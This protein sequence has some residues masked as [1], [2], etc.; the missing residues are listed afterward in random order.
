MIAA[1]TRLANRPRITSDID[2]VDPE[3]KLAALASKISLKVNTS[4]FGCS[5]IKIKVKPFK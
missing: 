1:Q 5:S 3:L 4:D 2:N